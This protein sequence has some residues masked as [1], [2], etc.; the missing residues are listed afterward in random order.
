MRP[1]GKA[2][3]NIPAFDIQGM[4][5]DASRVL[6]DDREILDKLFKQLE[7]DDRSTWDLVSISRFL[8]KGG[9]LSEAETVAN[10]ITVPW[11]KGLAYLQM[12]SELVELGDPPQGLPMLSA[13]VLFATASKRKESDQK[14]TDRVL[15]QVAE[16]FS[17]YNKPQDAVSAAEAIQDKAQREQTLKLVKSNS[18][19][20]PAK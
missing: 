16:A 19:A 7:S 18:Q 20:A 14:E 1:E 3:Q 12:G 11:Q 17:R 9:K 10:L 15:A 6:R 5:R 2:V 8:A 4:L 13:A